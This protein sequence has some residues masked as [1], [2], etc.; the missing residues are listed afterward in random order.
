M[1]EGTLF[2]NV[3]ED[4][5]GDSLKILSDLCD[6]YLSL[7]RGIEEREE[8]LKTWKESLEEVSRISIPAIM[9]SS[10]LSDV[11][12]ATGQKIEVRDKLKASVTESNYSLAYRNMTN[13][14]GG[15]A[16]ATKIVDSLFKSQVVI[17]DTSDEILELLLENEIPYET[18]RSI[19]WQTLHKYCREKLDK[20]EPIPEGISTFQYQETTIKI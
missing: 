11:R 15:D 9:N 12:L 17:E 16:N 3:K 13:A 2:E 18:K 10:G 7:K 5:N 19:H 4:L 8:E 1:S 20:G 6:R 14:E